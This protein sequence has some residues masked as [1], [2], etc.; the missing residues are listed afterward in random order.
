VKQTPDTTPALLLTIPDV[1]RLLGMS[2]A[3][4]YNLIRQDKLR[5]VTPLGT[6][7]VPRSE[8]NRLMQAL[9]APDQI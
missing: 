6:Q 5:T 2:R 7:R 8:V 3:S 4:V 9:G 1:A